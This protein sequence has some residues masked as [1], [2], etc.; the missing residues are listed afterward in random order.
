MRNYTLLTNCAQPVYGLRFQQPP[1]TALSAVV[2][3]SVISPVGIY[4]TYTLVKPTFV[5]GLVHPFLLFLVS[6]KG[7]VV[8]LIHR[9]NKDYNKFK[10]RNNS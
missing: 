3:P 8:H 2:T 5:L 4:S 6:V 1:A 9:T 7:R 10:I